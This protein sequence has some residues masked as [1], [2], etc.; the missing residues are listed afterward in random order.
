MQQIQIATLTQIQIQTL[1]LTQMA[2]LLQILW[3]LIKVAQPVPLGMKYQSNAFI[4]LFLTSA[5]EK[6]TKTDGNATAMPH[7]NL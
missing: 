3:L 1:T 6:M 2:A 7:T 4:V 5:S